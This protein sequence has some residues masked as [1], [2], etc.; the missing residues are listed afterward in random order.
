LISPNKQPNIANRCK[1]NTQSQP[2]REKSAAENRSQK[3]HEEK[4]K[5][6]KPNLAENKRKYARVEREKK[7]R[8]NQPNQEHQGKKK[9]GNC[10]LKREPQRYNPTVVGGQKKQKYTGEKT[11]PQKIHTE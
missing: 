8:Y 3:T 2:K 10:C 4:K 9:R 5:K 11:T 6:E 1:K 7:N